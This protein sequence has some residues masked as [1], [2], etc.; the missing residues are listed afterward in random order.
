MSIMLGNLSIEDMQKRTGI[1]FPKELVDY[2]KPRRQN[3]ASGIKP[4]EW[5]CYDIPFILVCGDM[6]TV[7]EIY[8][9]LKP[10][11]SDFK[12]TFKIAAS[13]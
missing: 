12:E 11:S 10:L 1:A 5:H 9:H 2:L 4:G 3:K 6:D 8:R 13:S 7:K